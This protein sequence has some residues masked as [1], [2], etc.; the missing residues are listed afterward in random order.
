MKAPRKKKAGVSAGNVWLKSATAPEMLVEALKQFGL[1][2]NEKR[3]HATE[4]AIINNSKR[5]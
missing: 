5:K 4:I 2:K 1:L 3:L